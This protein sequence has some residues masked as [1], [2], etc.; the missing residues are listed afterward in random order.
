[1]FENRRRK[2][3]IKYENNKGRS[4]GQKRQLEEETRRLE[5]TINMGRTNE[6]GVTDTHT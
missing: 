1:M 5:R 6:G 4:R 2:V 3:E